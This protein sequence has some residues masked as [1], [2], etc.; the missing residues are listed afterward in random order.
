MAVVEDTELT[1]GDAMDSVLG[2]YLESGI[3]Y[4]LKGAKEVFG[5]VTNFKSNVMD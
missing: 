3:R 5:G 1:W 2:M 4:L